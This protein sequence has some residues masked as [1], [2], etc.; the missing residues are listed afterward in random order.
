MTL[1]ASDTAVASTTSAA[2][3]V[4]DDPDAGAKF[5]FDLGVARSGES[6][7]AVVV[8]VEAFRAHPTGRQLGPS[9]AALPQWRELTQG[10]DLGIAWLLFTSP[11]LERTRRGTMLVYC[12][13]GDAKIDRWLDAKRSP[14]DAGPGVHAT[15]GRADRAE[16]VF[17]RPQSHVVAV[18]PPDSAREVATLLRSAHI[19]P[20]ADPGEAFRFRAKNPQS[21]MRELPASVTEIR[22]WV[23]PRKDQGADF[24]FE[25]DTPGATFVAQQLHD[26]LT[27]ENES[28]VRN[29]TLGL[30]DHPNIT[31]DGDIAKV[32][33]RATAAQLDALLLLVQSDL[34]P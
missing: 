15:L 2:S 28:S 19:P 5:V 12:A 3:V 29:V 17:M 11:S 26:F 34:G 16:R 4:D 18:V 13:A 1:D 32:H 31:A 21:V 14:F 30:F 20:H 6:K 33:V 10:A 27:K 9:I 24:F 7:V 23:A 25:G 22:F 8:N